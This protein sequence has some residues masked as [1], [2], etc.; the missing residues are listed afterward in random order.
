[1]KSLHGICSL[2]LVPCI[3]DQKSIECVHDSRTQVSGPAL[4]AEEPILLQH[5]LVECGIKV[6]AD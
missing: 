6:T 4:G 1:M 2:V 5:P 3:T